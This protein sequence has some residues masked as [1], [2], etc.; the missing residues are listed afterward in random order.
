MTDRIEVLIVDDSPFVR[1]AVKR[2]LAPLAQ[3]SIA[4]M[5]ANGREA[6]EQAKALRP[7]VIV[8]DIAMPEVDGLEAI[9]QIM[10]QTP[11]PILVLSSHARPG[12]ETTLKA[13]DLGAV[14]FISKS[15]AGRRMDIY[16]LAPLLREKVVAVARSRLPARGGDGGASERGAGALRPAPPATPALSAYD[17]LAVGASTGGP[18]ALVRILSALPATFPAGIVIAQHMPP[19]FTDTL[20]QRLDR[21]SDLRVREAV[22]GDRVEPGVALLGVGGRQL[23]VERADDGLRVRVPAQPDR[24][25]H[26]PSVDQLLASVASAAGPRAV[27]IVLTGMGQDGAEGLAELRRAGGRT[28]AES[29]ESAVIYGMPRAAREHAERV[30]PLDAVPRAI[31][32][33]FGAGGV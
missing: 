12:A 25:L 23:R 10:D 3:V 13:L 33:L 28:L 1:S 22:D 5:A 9:R 2:M 21:R 26:R 30:L 14:E 7:D 17:V 4:G 11:T 20:A 19:G 16:E 8:L 15:Q 29:E 6:V 31:L 32:E 27:G 24:F 18:R